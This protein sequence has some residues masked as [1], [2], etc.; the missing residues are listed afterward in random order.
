MKINVVQLIG[1]FHSGGSER[2]A[3]QLAGSLAKE[4]SYKV[5]LATMNA[6]GP[7]A[8]EAAAMGFDDVPEFRLTS[9]YDAN[10]VTQV[11]ACAR[12]L[13]ERK[14]DVVQ[15]HDFYTNVFGLAAM[16]L[17]GV[18]VKVA[19]KRE[20]LG[21]RTPAQRFIERQAFRFADVVVAN[22]A[23]V[24]DFLIGEG[25]VPDKVEVI[26]NG[27][28]LSRFPEKKPDRL[29]VLGI[30]GLP[31]DQSNKLVTMVANLRHDVKN[32][33]M[34][35][36]AA[37]LVCDQR[38]DVHFVLAGDGELRPDL[39]HM[40]HELGIADRVHFIGEC[41]TI[42]NLLSLSFAGVLTSRHEGFSNSILEYMAVGLPVV[43]TDVG[44]ASEAITDGETGFLVASDD[45]EALAARLME[46]LGSENLSLQMGRR[47][48]E[49]IRAHF[50]IE[51]QRD[52][53]LALYN[54]KLGERD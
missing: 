9:F 45:P 3:L 54:K 4:S 20:T 27:L 28:D 17:A 5:F 48:R 32:H 53:T 44:G 19:S 31:L 26:H 33:P 41:H 43:A 51:A 30:L 36:R 23:K 47:G 49:K 14:I 42:P 8:T 22:S 46:L 1:S 18:K 6:E 52:K 12:F 24:K 29:A 16:R 11:R 50:S 39:E 34:L 7:L 35:L 40:A 21:V 25:V 10:F 15:T 37:S 38:T 13:R 2:Q